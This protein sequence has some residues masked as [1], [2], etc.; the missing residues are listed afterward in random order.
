MFKLHT[1]QSGFTLIELLV[2]IAIIGLLSSVVLAS[3]NTARV[4]ARNVRRLADLNQY[5]LALQFTFDADNAFPGTTSW[6]CIGDHDDDKCW[7]S[8]GT[9][10]NEDPTVATALERF[11]K[12]RPADEMVLGSWQGVIYRLCRTSN[13]PDPE[14]DCFPGAVTLRW[15]MEGINQ[16]CG[17]GVAI[18]PA[19]Q[20]VRTYCKL[21]MS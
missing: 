2:V 15:M 21:V 7:Q 4:K 1:K 20:G 13:L 5:Q 11:L 17:S 14:A 12:P 3:L 9:G 16:S 10:I 18:S 8:N 19:H 6:S